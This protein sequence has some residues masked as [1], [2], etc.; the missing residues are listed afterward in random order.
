[1]ALDK[2]KGEVLEGLGHKYEIAPNYKWRESQLFEEAAMA[3]AE[4]FM[5]SGALWPITFDEEEVLIQEYRE[6]NQIAIIFSKNVRGTEQ[7]YPFVWDLPA[8]MVRE[9]RAIGKWEALKEH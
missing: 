7:L 5:N 6:S 8:D 9:L 2:I 3:A 1:M 4:A